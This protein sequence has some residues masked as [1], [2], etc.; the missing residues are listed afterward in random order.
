MCGITGYTHPGAVDREALSRMT[1]C[2]ARRGP[3][4]CGAWFDDAIAL[5]HR[6]LSVLDL[7]ANAD[8]PMANDDESIIIVYNGECYNHAELRQLLPGVKWRST[9]DTETLLR[10]YEKFGELFIEKVN[11]M[12]ALAIHDR[13]A[14]KL[15]LYRDRL[16][17]KPL[18][19]AKAGSAFLFAS[20]PAAFLKH[21]HFSRDLN[22]AG[23]A[24]FF[25]Y[26][27]LG[28]ATSIH[29]NVRRLPPAHWLRHDLETG[30]T[31]TAHYWS[32]EGLETFSARDED[33]TA[34]FRELFLDS[35]RLRTLSDVPL[36]CFLSGGIDS[37]AVAYALTKAGAGAVK[38]FNIGFAEKQYD[39]S[40]HAAQVARILGTTHE[41]FRARPADCLPLIEELPAVC[42]EPFADPSILPTMLLARMT[43]RNVTV[44]L[45]GDGGDELLLGYDRYELAQRVQGAF[46]KVPDGLRRFCARIAA[47]IP[48]YRLRMIAQGLQYHNKADLYASVFIGWN[49]WFVRKLLKP[50]ALRAQRFARDS[51]HQTLHRNRFLPL[52]E[53]A[54]IAD[55]Q[56]YLPD[57]VLTKVDRA[58]M[59]YSLEGRAPMLDHRLVE[60]ARRLPTRLKMKGRRQKI[61]LKNLL[62]EV[63]PR[64]LLERPKA[65]FA[66]PLRHW[67]RVELREMMQDLL[68][69]AS[70]REHGL[71]DERFVQSLI[72]DH[73]SGRWNYERQLWALMVFQLWHR[74]QKQ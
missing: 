38:T 40:R 70:L 56:H 51:F 72:R 60:F 1:E 55:L 12:F 2:L 8:Q 67:L 73:L 32:P 10:L 69:P 65:G 58:T 18:Y 44:A 22:P 71:V 49:A 74:A 3:D 16:G 45:S 57:D 30:R 20:D 24:Q 33:L 17:E 62:G 27:Y 29:R 37:S 19:Y 36:G 52:I 4:G 21:P 63:L 11:G 26:N 5:G 50:E 61:V 68:S 54:A 25:T 35:V 31:T 28:G 47:H 59:H 64:P 66:V 34:E 9:G 53:Q 48:H 6:R 39:E 43:R 7:T 41:S 42:G 23:V 15:L 14:R 13:R 46:A